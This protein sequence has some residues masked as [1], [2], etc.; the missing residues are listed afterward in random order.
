M[1][2]RY[3]LSRTE[4]IRER[5][6]I[7]TDGFELRQRFNV[8]P[9]QIMPVITNADEKRLQFMQ[10]GLVPFWSKEKSIAINARIEGILSKPSFREPIRSARCLIPACGFYE[11]KKEKDGKVPHHIRRKDGALIAFAGIYDSWTTADGAELRSFAI[12]TTAANEFMAQIHNR[13]PVML[14][15]EQEEAWL[16]TEAACVDSLIA[17][18]QSFAGDELEMCPVSKAVNYGRNDSAELLAAR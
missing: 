17:C 5:F 7:N 12:V 1:C 15:S 4:E 2:G 6:G 16:A 18:V 9:E 11:W 3:T 13:M 8:C 14:S 10:W